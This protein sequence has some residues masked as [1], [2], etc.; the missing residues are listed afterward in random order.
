MESIPKEA[1]INDVA[2]SS[3]QNSFTNL[4]FFFVFD[5]LFLKINIF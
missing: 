2:R 3:H 5:F 4:D 1:T